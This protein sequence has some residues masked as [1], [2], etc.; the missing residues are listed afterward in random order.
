MTS[1]RP[2]SVLLSADL[3]RLTAKHLARYAVMLAAHES[4]EPGFRAQELRDLLCTWRSVQACGY[5]AV[6]SGE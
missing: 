2:T 1:E 3:E 4:G 6:E 5:D